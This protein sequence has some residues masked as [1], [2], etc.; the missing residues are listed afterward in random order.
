MFKWYQELTREFT[1]NNQLESSTEL[2][3]WV[4]Q[5]ITAAL[6]VLMTSTAGMYS[7]QTVNNCTTYRYHTPKIEN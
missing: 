3:Q 6:R 1:R 4:C 2:A 5:V 7:M